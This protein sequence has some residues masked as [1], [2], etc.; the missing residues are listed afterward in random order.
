MVL[1][2]KEDIEVLLGCGSSQHS[3]IYSFP[4]NHSRV[5]PIVTMTGNNK[6]VKGE[7]FL[8]APFSAAR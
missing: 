8:E 3:R 7:G 2:T 1:Q 5:A 4:G 6:T